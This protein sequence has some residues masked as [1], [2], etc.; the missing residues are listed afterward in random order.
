MKSAPNLSTGALI[1]IAALCILG[2]LGGW[3]ILLYGGFHHQL[4]RFSKETTF[5][6]G[7]PALFMAAISFTLSVVALAALLQAMN[8][9]RSWYF[10]LCGGVVVPPLVFYML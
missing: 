1:A 6:V 10:L 5:V 4:S 8:S 2:L 3:L 9:S 7:V